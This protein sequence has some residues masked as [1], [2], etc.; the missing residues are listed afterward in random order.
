M[1]TPHNGHL[2]DRKKVAVVE[3]AVIGR[4]SIFIVKNILM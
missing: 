3:V 1:E 2:G 4:C